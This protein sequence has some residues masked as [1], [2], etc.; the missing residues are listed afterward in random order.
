MKKANDKMIII[1]SKI[2]ISR[3][4]FNNIIIDTNNTKII[5]I[6]KIYYFS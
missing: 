1:I 2:M 3:N 6:P 4:I 5:I